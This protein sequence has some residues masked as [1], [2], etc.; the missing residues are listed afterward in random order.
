MYPLAGTIFNKSTTPL[1]KWFYAIYLFSVSKNGVA[2]KELER[3]VGVSYKTA[4]R[5]EKQIRLLMQDETPKL[6]KNKR[7]KQADETFIGGKR[8]QS[9]VKDNKTAVLG[10][11]EQGG[12]V[13][14]RIAE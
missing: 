1:K 7:P 14:T 10:V 12:Y 9:E 11:L 3:H 8:K 5:M 4:H 13:K 2:A 6:R